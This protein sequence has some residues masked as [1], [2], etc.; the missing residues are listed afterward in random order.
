MTAPADHARE[1]HR[2]LDLALRAG[3]VLLSGGVGAAEVTAACTAVAE[4]AGLYAVACD[5]TFTSISLAGSGGPGEPPVTEMRLVT[6]RSLDYT[7]VTAVH[8]LI[9]DLVAGRLDRAEAEDRLREITTARHPYGPE[10]VRRCPG[11]AGRPR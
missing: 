9:G 8:N 1:V 2:T 3:E 4:A 6:Q 11:R 7:R 10:V 5:I